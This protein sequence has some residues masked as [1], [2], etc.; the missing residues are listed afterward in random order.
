MKALKIDKSRVL[1]AS[2]CGHLGGTSEARDEWREDYSL[3]HRGRFDRSR[4]RGRARYRQKGCVDPSEAKR[5]FTPQMH[6]RK[7]G[8]C[9]VPGGRNQ[10][11]SLTPPQDARGGKREYRAKAAC[12]GLTIWACS[13]TSL[14]RRA[15]SPGIPPPRS[16]R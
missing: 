8:V 6:D 4:A 11:R 16:S 13:A 2:A 1:C 7:A 9:L 12:M 3:E 15:R 10:D 5:P 14:S